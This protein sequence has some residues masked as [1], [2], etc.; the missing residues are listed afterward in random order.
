M[1]TLSR[2]MLGYAL[3]RNPQA[4]DR[5]LIGDMIEAGN[6]AS[7]SDLAIQVVTSRQFRYRARRMGAAPIPEETVVR[8][9]STP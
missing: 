7:F 4:S 8:S 2:K 6:N 1:T 5:R 3:G 9:R